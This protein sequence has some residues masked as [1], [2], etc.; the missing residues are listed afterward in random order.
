VFVLA[1]FGVSLAARVSAK[2]RRL[3]EGVRQYARETAEFIAHDTA[4]VVGRGIVGAALL[5]GFLG[6]SL[7]STQLSILSGLIHLPD[8]WKYGVVRRGMEVVIGGTQLFS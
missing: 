4:Q 5:L 2:V 7:M 6:F 8:P 3:R 1:K